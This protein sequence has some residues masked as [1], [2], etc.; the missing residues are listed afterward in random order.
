MTT[1]TLST[2]TPAE[3]ERITGLAQSSMRD[4]R[5]RGLIPVNNGHARFDLFQLGELMVM[6][7]LADLGVGPSGTGEIARLCSVG[8][9]YHALLWIG[10]YEGD[11]LLFSEIDRAPGQ[12]LGWGDNAPRLAQAVLSDSLGHR[13]DPP[14]FYIRWANG[15]GSFSHS[16]D[17]AFS[18][19][20]TFSPQFAGP[21][22]V[23][24]LESIASNLIDGAARPFV[25][26]EID[27]ISSEN[28][29]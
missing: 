15:E 27:E 19:K 12:E 20:A 24:D 4:W 6:K 22:F 25:H 2:F 26:V 5:R 10:A 21:V 29:G 23:F 16:L 7:M 14:R 9:A 11:H 13:M 8:I 3:A 17:R 1:F 28:D 18:F